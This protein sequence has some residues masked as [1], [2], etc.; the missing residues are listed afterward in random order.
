MR[1][2]LD[3]R[4]GTR[5][6]RSGPTPGSAACSWPPTGPS[7]PR[8]STGERY[9]ARRGGRPGRRRRG[10]PGCDRRRDARALPPHRPHRAL[11]A[12]A[13]RRRRTP[14]GVRPA[15][16]QPGRQRAEPSA[17]RAAGVEVEGGL[18]V[19][20]AR[21]LNRAWTFAVEHGRPFVTWKFA[22]TLDGRSAAADGTS[23]WVSSR[24]ARLDT[25]RLRAECDVMLVGSNTVEVDDPE[26]TVRD[27]VDVPVARQPL[28]VVMGERDLDPGRRVFND[29]A[30]TLHL[31]TR[32]PHEALAALYDRDRQHVFLEGG[33]TLAAAFLAAG[34]VDEVVAYVAPMLLGAGPQRRRRPRDRHHRRRPPPDRHRRRRA[35]GPRRRGHQRPAHAR[36]RKGPLMFTGIVEELGT[37]AALEDQ[38]DAV[39]LTVGAD[40]R[41]RGR[42]ARRLDLGQRLL[43]HRQRARRR[44]VDR[45][46][47][48]GDP[49]Q[50]VARRAGR[51]R[52]GQ[53]GARRHPRPPGSAA[54]SCRGTST[55]SARS[56]SGRPSD[57][58]DV[59]DGRRSPRT[60]PTLARRQGLGRGRRRQPHRR[61]GR[62]PDRFT[63]SL[64]PETLARTTLGT[65]APGERVNLEMDVIAKHVANLVRAYKPPPGGTR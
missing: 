6:S 20:E 49:R 33:P 42:P 64:I 56:S 53:P 12:G 44:H 59:V 13:G 3:A 60:W 48:A 63:V 8:A 17:L 4:R 38:G 18:L 51:R 34:L 28:R 52:P 43:P 37:V 5:V 24:A 58:W 9:A 40:R 16:R 21:A 2:A 36:A 30:E 32:D 54:T 57:H 22:T 25:H 14:G 23:R 47:D 62:T 1:R 19:D 27:E 41:A 35:A 11:L 31:R 55:P 7:S 26:L 46:R 15:R 45:R 10:R 65:R 29:R 61:R 50:D 39:R